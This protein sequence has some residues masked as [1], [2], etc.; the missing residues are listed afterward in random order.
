MRGGV[1]SWLVDDLTPKE[2]IG[3]TKEST[4]GEKENVHYVQESK[5]P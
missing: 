3:R 5:N 4:K 2:D 1:F